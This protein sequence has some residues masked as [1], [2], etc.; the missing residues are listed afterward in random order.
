MASADLTQSHELPVTPVV[1]ISVWTL[2]AGAGGMLVS[3]AFLV[4]G[5]SVDL[6]AGGAGFMA[7][8]VLVAAGVISLAVLSRSPATSEAA[9]HTAGCLVG[10]LPLTVAALSWPT[11][12]FGTLLGIIL[13]PLILLGCIGWAWIQNRRVANHLSELFKLRR[14]RL[15]RVTLFVMQ[16]LAIVATWPLFL[17]FLEILQSMGFKTGWS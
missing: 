1:T 9:I 8:A 17:Y 14:V 3:F 5:G 6:I 16:L 11:L 2:F 4:G 10:L 7:G 13:M 15:L 12:W